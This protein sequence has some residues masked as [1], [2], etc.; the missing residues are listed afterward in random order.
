MI[1]KIL[2]N[3]VRSLRDRPQTARARISNRVPEGSA[4]SFISPS[5]GVLLAQFSLYVYKG[6]LK[7]TFHFICKDILNV[8]TAIS[9]LNQDYMS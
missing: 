7:K 9:D 3:I 8:A 4:M 6:D 5:S 2:F 1:V